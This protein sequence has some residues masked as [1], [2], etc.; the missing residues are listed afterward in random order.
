[1]NF[2]YSE[3]CG[4]ILFE[5]KLISVKTV[6]VK[7]LPKNWTEVTPTPKT[8]IDVRPVRIDLQASSV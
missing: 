8:Y 5:W 3:I 6:F 1:M 4:C 2:K 7:L